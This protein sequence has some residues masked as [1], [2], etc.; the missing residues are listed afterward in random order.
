MF[1]DRALLPLT[2][3]PTSGLFLDEFK[4]CRGGIPLQ[5]HKTTKGGSLMV[6]RVIST[7]VLVLIALAYGVVRADDSHMMTKEQLRSMLGK[8]DVI[9]IDVRTNY[10][11]DNS[12]VKIPGAVREEG[13]KFGSW[14]NKYPKDK[15]IVLYCN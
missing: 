13:M 5:R 9:I 14:M 15:T 1:K 10:D 7:V 2:M 4:T 3:G 11:W 6:R 12:K 8:P